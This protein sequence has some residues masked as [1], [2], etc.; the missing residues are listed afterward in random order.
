MKYLS[1]FNDAGLFSKKEWLFDNKTCN[2]LQYMLPIYIF[3][4][5]YSI[6]KYSKNMDFKKIF[7]IIFIA[8]VIADLMTAIFHCYYIDRSFSNDIINI[9][10]DYLIINTAYGYAANHH[11]FPSNWKDISDKTLYITLLS[12]FFIPLILINIY[13]KYNEIGFLL[14]LIIFFM[15]I[16]PIIHKYCHEKNHNRYVPPIIDFFINNKILLHPNKHSK[17]HFNNIY[18]WS[19]LNGISDPLVNNF[20]RMKC[21]LLNICPKEEIIKSCKDYSKKYNTDIIKIKFIGDIEG[22]L[23]VKLIGNLFIYA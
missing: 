4:L 22:K 16:S 21:D 11:M 13:I 15:V 7:L 8:F 17:H 19:L 10:N 18:D 23:N 12:I 3:I 6:Y 9:E 5:S 14:T 2:N 1:S 20:I